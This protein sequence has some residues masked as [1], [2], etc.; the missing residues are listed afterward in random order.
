[1]PCNETAPKAHIYF[2]Y[3]TH[4]YPPNPAFL[5]PPWAIP[6][7]FIGC[8]DEVRWRSLRVGFATSREARQ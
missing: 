3:I 4:I 6:L 5:D 7:E 1:M 2:F 8:G